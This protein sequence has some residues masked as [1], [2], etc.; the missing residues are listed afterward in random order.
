MPRFRFLFVPLPGTF[1]I[2]ARPMKIQF[3][4]R[5]KQSFSLNRS[6]SNSYRIKRKYI[7]SHPSSIIFHLFI[8]IS[9]F[10]LKQT[11]TKAR[12]PSTMSYLD[13]LDEQT[14]KMIIS[15][16]QVTHEKGSTREEMI[17]NFNG[18][19]EAFEKTKMGH[20]TTMDFVRK[21]KISSHASLSSLHSI[22]LAELEVGNTYRGCAVYCRIAT[23]VL[24]SSSAMLLVEDD[25]TIL[26]L[27]I[28]GTFDRTKLKEGR[29]IAIKEPF[30]KLRND[31]SNGIRVDEP[32][33]IIF[34]AKKTTETP[35]KEHVVFERRTVEER[36]IELVI[37]NPG[38]GVEKLHIQLV[39][40]GY[41]ISKQRVRALK[42]VVRMK[43]QGNDEN[44][45]T[46]NISI[47]PIISERRPEKHRVYR[48][49]KVF[50]YKEA[51]NK[52][53]LSKSY[54]QAEKFY[55]EALNQ[56]NGQPE[57]SSEEVSLWQLYSNRSAARMKLGMLQEALQDGLKSNMCA[58]ADAVKPLL[59]CTEAL[60]YLGLYTE[61]NDLLTA[62][63]DEFLDS[64]DAIEKKRRALFSKTTLRVGK[65]YECKTISDAI[66]K[67]PAGAE[68]IVDSGTYRESLFISKPLTLRCN[69]VNDCDAILSIEG[70]STCD[71]AEIQG[72]ITYYLC[73]S[74]NP[75]PIHIIGFKISCDKP[76]HLSYQAVSIKSG[77]A[78]LR[79]CT[80]QSSSGPAVSAENAGTTVIIQG[81]S[82][83][84]GAQGGILVV[85]GARLS[86]KQV[87]C[88]R[89]A[90]NGLELR[91]GGAASLDDCH[92]YSNGRQGIMAWQNAGLLEAKRCVIHSHNNESGVLIEESRATFN[93]C[94][95]YGNKL[96]GIV[97]QNKGSICIIDCEVHNNCEGVLIQDTGNAHVEN[98]KIYMNRSNGI[99]VGFDHRGSAAII[100]N[101]VHDNRSKGVYIANIGNVVTRDNVEYKNHCLPPQMSSVGVNPKSLAISNKFL[102]NVKKNKATIQKAAKES[103]PI[104]LFGHIIN[105]DVNNLQK[106]WDDLEE[107]LDR[108]SY[109]K[110][111]PQKN[112]RFARCNRCKT[113]SYCSSKCQKL[114][115]P[116]HKQVCSPTKFYPSFLDNNVSV[117]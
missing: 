93:D 72:S 14:H 106:T 111:I 101:E 40:E 29:M 75:H 94:E 91:S 12:Q 4:N 33:D 114:H 13:I 116:E 100:E 77:V 61:A 63:A 99:F 16:P 45:Q 76:L 102:K 65:E 70:T 42:K 2:F 47:I 25:S 58:P 69:T 17:T 90:A 73:D 28:Y 104:S 46:A 8:V 117:V 10:I 3:K 57:E 26:D 79:N 15:P 112:K 43:S 41:N 96:A 1:E 53:L 68:I 87:H 92:F 88:C 18:E 84:G 7:I 62:T 81:C 5:S 66:R 9:S 105:I 48:V 78:V 19:V 83:H 24:D 31:G 86:M 52:A 71:W 32:A 74:A 50:E 103:N 59:R 97:S 6:W 55:S 11:L 37:E 64:R 34:D 115:W 51:G 95:I 109:C 108:C 21:S 98:C 27:A 30:F 35:M 44:N 113:V 23:R 110:A 85:G 89:N 82:V 36:L 54:E 39:D 49:P 56:K 67:A 107:V 22:S 38:K 60:V 80:I 20:N